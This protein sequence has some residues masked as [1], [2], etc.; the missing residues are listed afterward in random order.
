MF[1]TDWAKTTREGMPG[2]SVRQH[3]TAVRYVAEELL[4]LF[5]HFCEDNGLEPQA[6]AFLAAAHD[7]GKIS[8]DFLQKCQA[9]LRL[10]GI[11]REANNYGWAD[12][13]TRWHPAISQQSL[14]LF[15]QQHGYDCETAYFWAAVV[16][17]HHGRLLA[18]GSAR[19]C[20]PTTTES[21][22]EDA[23][24]ECLLEFWEACGQPHLKNISGD[25]PCL[26]SVAGLV[27]LADWLGSDEDYY[28]AGRELPEKDLREA[29][30]KAVKDTGL[31]LPTVTKGLDFA[32]IFL[33][34]V[35]YPM[36]TACTTAITKPGIYVLEAPMGMGKTEAALWTAYNLLQVGQAQGVYFALPTQATSNLMFLRLTDFARRICPDVTRVQLIHG[37][38]WLCDDLK[39][40]SIPGTVDGPK[41]ETPLR[42]D[43]LWFNTTRRALFAPFGVGTVDQALL[44]VL[45]VRHFPL[46]RF[47]LSRKVVILDEVHTYDVYTGTLIRCLC[48]ELEQLGCT[49]LILS[50]T[51]T[52]SVR[53]GL[54]NET[55]SSGEDIRA[56]YP[57]L[58]GCNDGVAIAPRTPPAPQDKEVCVTHAAPDAARREALKLA[59]C[60][61]Q[62]L[63]VCDTV[64]SA[65][66]TYQS[67][68]QECD[69]TAIA[70][71]LLHSR[72]PFYLRDSLEKKWMARF[73]QGGA[74]SCGAI[75]V[76]TQI[77][78]QSV[79]LDAD[80]LFSELAPTDMLLQRLGR[81]WRHRRE[82]R[83]V[84]APMFCLLDEVVS[85]ESLYCMDVT[86]I[87][88]TLGTKGR[89][90]KP[91][92]LLR[93]LEQWAGRKSLSLPSGIRP[94][95]T[96]TYETADCPQA[97]QELEVEKWG[98]DLAAQTVA[99]MG[100][101]IWKQLYDDAILPSTRISDHKDYT[102]V[103]CIKDSGNTLT[104][105]ENNLVV[106]VHRNA[107]TL[108]TVKALHRNAV[109][110]ADWYFVQRPRDVRLAPFHIDGCLLVREDGVVEG[111]GIVP[112][113]HIYWD[114]VL[115]LAV[116][117][118]SP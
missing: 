64:D 49:V 16:G 86:A 118:E 35:P 26:W 34:K 13:Y 48:K 17:A 63:W 14:Q 39:N 88:K 70:L 81:L 65:Q 94:L 99:N 32:D 15:L 37:N 10:E 101:N 105:L 66:Q 7:V 111:P 113:K 31:G 74:R 23:R 20:H 85:L 102:F 73:S 42:S 6:V 91:W 38:A 71:G 67:L 43:G 89:V 2:I 58:T 5:P 72:F 11:E 50:A 77:V 52:E 69:D 25:D 62:V 90:Y 92:V 24:Q 12:I 9:W 28:P 18:D 4:R 117:K 44:A 100:T 56:P 93:S 22:L 76:S 75:L 45:A 107:P 33:G 83:P 21:K 3:C 53:C 104:L 60:G 29:A 47:A 112:G 41:N 106:H 59:S 36:Q 98:E 46:R 95:M 61:A 109:K 97:W 115:G 57:R 54:L 108:E 79:D 110:V 27:T 55:E 51:L 78:E 80:V 96:A 82:N 87:K 40:L 116:Q 30:S 8:L 19:P 103:L 68:K 84:P 114:D 1:R